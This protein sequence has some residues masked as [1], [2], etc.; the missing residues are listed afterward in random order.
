MK[1]TIQQLRN[2]SEGSL[3]EQQ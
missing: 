2:H 1:F 3:A